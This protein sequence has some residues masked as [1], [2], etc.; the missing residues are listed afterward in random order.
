[1]KPPAKNPCHW[2]PFRRTSKA[3]YLGEAEP[4]QFITSVHTGMAMPC[5]ITVDYNDPKW[6]EKLDEA[7]Q[8]AGSAI[9][10]TH[11]S[12]LPR[13]LP[14]A[15]SRLPANQPLVFSNH[16]EFLEHHGGKKR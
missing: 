10:L 7:H 14:G 11:A 6:Q 1:M 15:A 12:I 8:C 9:Y 16:V 2:C 5:H 13:A 3:G 4:L